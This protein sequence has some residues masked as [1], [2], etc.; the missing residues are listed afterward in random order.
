[1]LVATNG[2]DP[3]TWSALALTL[4]DQNRLAE[5]E[6]AY[7]QAS[8]VAPAH[9]AAHHNLGALLA[10]MERAEE[11]LAELE[12]AASLGLGGH[13]LAFNRGRALTQLY[14]FE[15]AERAYAQAVALDPHNTDAHL[16]LTQLRY[17]RGDPHFARDISAAAA[18]RDDTELQMLLANILRQVGDLQGSEVLLRDVLARKGPMPQVRSALAT[19]LHESGRLREAQREALEAAAAQPGNVALIENLVSIQLSLG[20]PDDA[21]PFIWTQRSLKPYEQRWIA[22]EATA[23]RLK[24]DPRYREL[25][26][27]DRLVRYY[28]LEPPQGWRSMQELN[29]A[30]VLALNARHRLA[31]HPF[32]QSLRNGSQT[33]RSLLADA[34]PAIQAV[35][36]A[37]AGPLESYRTAIGTSATHP[38]SA[39]N[40]GQ[41]L[42]SGAWSVRLQC[43]G[44]HVNHV[45]PNGWISSAYYV[46]VPQETYDEGA[47]SGW[48]KFGETRLPVPG[49][50]AEHFVQPLPGRL[51]LFPT[52]MWHGTNAIH[53]LE[54][55]LTIAFDAVPAAATGP[56]RA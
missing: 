7:R 16:N 5:A 22:Y 27:Y 53:G 20:E 49:A 55:R 52:Y 14:R 29:A 35:L 28:D 4:R 48:I 8:A 42:M 11:A 39:R 19:V 18:N 26:D 50:A 47:T 45:H 38:L 32:D 24:R 54:P 3:Q 9:A 30:L 34:D 33:A 41:T 25:Y 37:F 43:E 13:E 31:T 23:L 40:R 15:E 51:V 2:R 46:S 10:E 6:V 12:R 17:M 56:E 1:V 36:K 21:L 44:F